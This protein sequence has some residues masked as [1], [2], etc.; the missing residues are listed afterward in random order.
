MFAADPG[1]ACC[2][3]SAGGAGAPLAT[4]CADNDVAPSTEL[5]SNPPKP[6]QDDGSRGR[7]PNESMAII[8]IHTGSFTLEGEVERK[9]GRG[10]R[11]TTIGFDF[12]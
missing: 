4:G 12:Q 9:V 11:G 10:R 7:R 5:T 1:E 8:G 3:D 6:V 2:A